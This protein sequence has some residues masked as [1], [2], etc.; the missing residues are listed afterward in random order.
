MGS[1]IEMKQIFLIRHGATAQNLQRRY[2]GV[3]DEPLSE[4]GVV[5]AETLAAHF[6]NEDIS[7]IYSSPLSR[8]LMTAEAIAH[9]HSITVKTL[10]KLGEVN[11]G[12]WEGLTFDEIKEQFPDEQSQWFADPDNFTFP[13]GESVKHFRER[14]L[15]CLDEILAAKGDTV[16]VAHGGT[17]RF[18]LCNICKWPMDCLHSFELK[19]AG[20]TILNQYENSCVVEVL[21]DTCHLKS[22]GAK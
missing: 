1:E 7:S 6:A 16:V 12:L 10:D 17:L 15:S 8:A 22:E 11:F 9:P 21:N 18:I 20:V 5:Q 2:L 3:T 14:V 13:E 4:V 19:N